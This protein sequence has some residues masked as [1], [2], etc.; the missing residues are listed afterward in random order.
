MPGTP[1]TLRNSE[2]NP[3]SSTPQRESR[4]HAG[5]RRIGAGASCR[6][7][8]SALS[9]DPTS[10]GVVAMM[11]RDPIR[12]LVLRWASPLALAGV[13]LADSDPGP[14]AGQRHGDRPARAGQQ[15]HPPLQR[16]PAPRRRHR[17]RDR[18]DPARRHPRSGA[19]GPPQDPRR[20]EGQE[21]DRPRR[22]QV[23]RGTRNTG[24]SSRS[25]PG[26]TSGPPTRSG[27]PRSGASGPTPS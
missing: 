21:Q 12:R 6:G 3:R 16:L 27:P 23:Q 19:E 24:P 25:T 17:R 26:S 1:P 13:G 14:E 7:W 18:A 11:S 15:D 4:D 2:G 22:G 8:S 20:D 9:I 10:P 5:T